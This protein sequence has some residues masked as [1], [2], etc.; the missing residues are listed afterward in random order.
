MWVIY[1]SVSVRGVGGVSQGRILCHSAYIK[2]GGTDN[3]KHANNERV[4]FDY[5]TVKNA[6]E[7]KRGERGCILNF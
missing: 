5:S 6:K 2:S 4:I 3:S 7:G 1:K